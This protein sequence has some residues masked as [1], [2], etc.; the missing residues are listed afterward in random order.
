MYIH[1]YHAQ[2]VVLPT[3]LH[4]P[5]RSVIS[6]TGS[7][8][9]TE[10]SEQH[11]YQCI[12]CLSNASLAGTDQAVSSQRTAFAL[13]EKLNDVSTC[14]VLIR[15]LPACCCLLRKHFQHLFMSFESYVSTTTTHG[16]TQTLQWK[17]DH[18]ILQ[19]RPC[20]MD[21]AV[22]EAIGK[23]TDDK[24]RMIGMY[25]KYWQPFGLLLTDMER[26]GMSV[27]RSAYYQPSTSLVDDTEYP[28]RLSASSL[29]LDQAAATTRAA[30]AY[31]FAAHAV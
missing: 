9:P 21:K 1:I 27:N 16:M 15:P 4:C 12:V 30:V 26:E 7:Q 29:K 19:V 20:V 3:S 14:I 22:Q 10:G 25:N 17:R 28:P 6:C 2:V 24:M 13:P 8:H 11:H 31:R 18:L 5:I 23:K